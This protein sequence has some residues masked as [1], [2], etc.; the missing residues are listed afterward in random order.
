MLYLIP[1]PP[2]LEATTTGCA[3][4]QKERTPQPIVINNRVFF[5][6]MSLS[7][8]FK[9]SSKLIRISLENKLEKL[10]LHIYLHIGI[11]RLTGQ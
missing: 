10:S 8:P 1:L 5:A 11:R 2:Y 4:M 7:K 6:E 9:L 3:T